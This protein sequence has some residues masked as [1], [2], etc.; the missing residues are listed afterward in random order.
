MLDCVADCKM[1]TRLSRILKVL[2]LSSCSP[3]SYSRGLRTKCE[4]LFTELN[5]LI[6]TPHLQKDE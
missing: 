2:E 1:A 4:L 3:V 5:S 6:A